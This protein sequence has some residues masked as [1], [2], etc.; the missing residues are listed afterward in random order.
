MELARA[1]QHKD[2]ISQVINPI[3]T[4]HRS[5]GID[6]PPGNLVI[7]QQNQWIDKDK[8]TLN[9]FKTNK[10]SYREAEVLYKTIYNPQIQYLLPFFSIPKKRYTTNH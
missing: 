1:T 8:H 7:T 9:I 4:L 2:S 5:L 6:I 3:Q 10:M